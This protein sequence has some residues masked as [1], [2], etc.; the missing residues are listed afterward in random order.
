MAEGVET[1]AQRKL[2]YSQMQGWLF[3]PAVPAAKLKQL[4]S[5]QAAAA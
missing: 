1:D 4:L 5:K 3:S 2:G